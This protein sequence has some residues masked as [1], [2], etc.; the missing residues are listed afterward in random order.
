MTSTSTEPRIIKTVT[1]PEGMTGRKMEQTASRDHNVSLIP[2]TYDVKV[3]RYPE[4]GIDS[5]SAAIPA[6][7]HAHT[8]STVEFGGVALAWEE[9]GGERETYWLHVYASEFF[10]ERAEAAGYVFGY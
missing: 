6:I 4:G 3:R 10:I 7:A 1:V 9:R 5:Y 2:G 8:A